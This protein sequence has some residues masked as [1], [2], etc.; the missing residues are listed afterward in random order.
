[1]GL[2]TTICRPAQLHNRMQFRS[3]GHH[4]STMVET[5]NER[6][7]RNISNLPAVHLPRRPRREPNVKS[8]AAATITA[9]M[10]QNGAPRRRLVCP[11]SVDGSCD[12][13]CACAYPAT[14]S[15]KTKAIEQYLSMTSPKTTDQR[16]LDLQA[17]SSDFVRLPADPGHEHMRRRGN[18]GC[19][20]AERCPECSRRRAS[21]GE[22]HVPSRSPAKWE[23]H[24][25]ITKRAA[26]VVARAFPVSRQARRG[27]SGR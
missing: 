13:V 4:P 12:V 7:A 2:R 11:N 20:G 23:G 17:G 21:S 1:M 10:I 14:T 22:E 24:R 26:G 15:T 16:S 5:L 6:A 9:T 19:E 8:R 18:A 25:V 3:A 27:R